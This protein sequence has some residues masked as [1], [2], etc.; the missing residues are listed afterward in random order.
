MYIS[1]ERNMNKDEISILLYIIAIMN[2]SKYQM[3]EVGK[4]QRIDS[5]LFDSL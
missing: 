2:W 1:G 3:K 5:L 4:V